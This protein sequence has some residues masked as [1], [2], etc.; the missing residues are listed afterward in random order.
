MQMSK[1]K[2][3][4]GTT[5][6]RR[7]QRKKDEKKRK[8]K[9]GEPQIDTDETQIKAKTSG[10]IHLCFICVNLWLKLIYFIDRVVLMDGLAVAYVGQSLFGG[11]F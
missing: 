9:R 3:G 7:H 8:V 10:V 2:S 11:G 6:A 5:K 4:E 1:G